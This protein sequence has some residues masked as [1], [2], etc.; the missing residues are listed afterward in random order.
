MKKSSI[1]VA[2][3]VIMLIGGGFLFSSRL[4]SKDLFEMNVEALA[5]VDPDVTIIPCVKAVSRC[6]FPAEDEE[7]NEFTM[8]VTGFKN[9]T[10]D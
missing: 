2:L 6:E 7:G 10:S 8:V 3:S 1:I 9:K 5:A 4:S